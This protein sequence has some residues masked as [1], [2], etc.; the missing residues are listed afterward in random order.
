M[1][2]WRRRLIGEGLAFLFGAVRVP[3][4]R[5]QTGKRN[6]DCRRSRCDRADLAHQYS[7]RAP[8]EGPHLVDLRWAIAQNYIENNPARTAGHADDSGTGG[9]SATG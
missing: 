1:A 5:P 6:H 8:G 3:E 4:A 2:G 7:D 9:H